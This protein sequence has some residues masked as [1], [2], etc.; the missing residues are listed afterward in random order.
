MVF[1]DKSSVSTH[2]CNP[3]TCRICMMVVQMN[4]LPKHEQRHPMCFFCQKRFPTEK[5]R[6]AHLSS[7]HVSCHGCKIYQKDEAS[8]LEHY[9]CCTLVPCPICARLT[10]RENFEEHYR[11]HPCCEFC[12]Q[13][14]SS[15]KVLADHI[16]DVHATCGQ[17]KQHFANEEIR[18]K[19]AKTCRFEPCL[20]C[21][22]II[23]IDKMDRHL[24]SH[25]SCDICHLT[26]TSTKMMKCHKREEH[27]DD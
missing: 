23:E 22:K 9:K 15:H 2:D 27:V 21:D 3:V 13:V 1:H 20:I 24:V 5:Q 11:K 8:L 26:F 17:C 19:H 25:P 4:D 16:S 7:T 10:P 18:N 12:Q 14:L 6:Q